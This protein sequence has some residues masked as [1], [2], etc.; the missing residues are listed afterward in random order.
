MSYLKGDMPTTAGHSKN[1]TRREQHTP[2]RHLQE[3]VD[4]K[5]SVYGSILLLLREVF[6]VC[7]AESGRREGEQHPRRRH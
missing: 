3:Y 4:P 7:V 1:H 6:M 5:D 2:D